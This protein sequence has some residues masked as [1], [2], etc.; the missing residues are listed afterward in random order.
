VA[1]VVEEAPPQQ[2]EVSMRT[3]AA[4]FRLCYAVAVSALIA[5]VAPV[6]EAREAAGQDSK[7]AAAAKELSQVLDAAKLD[8]I[9]APD[10]S[11]PNSFVAA[12][13][14]QGSQMLVVSAKYAA[15]LLLVQK[16]KEKNF[17]DIYIDLSSAS[18]PGTKVFVM[19]ASADGLA[20]KPGDGGMDSWEQGT[21]QVA[22]DGEWKKAKLTEDEYMKAFTEADDRYAK[23]LSLLTAQAKQV[24]GTL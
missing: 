20:A 14:F 1:K 2:V 18:M 9:A 21:K 7:S 10:P 12:L 16:L 23:L 8:A 6:P 17:R 11:D 15:P 4:R 24:K 3:S 5:A 13:Y 22:F 19:D